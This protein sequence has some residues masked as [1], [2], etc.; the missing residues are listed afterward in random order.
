MMPLGEDLRADQQ[1]DR[2]VA[3]VAHQR[4]R[5]R[6]PADRVAGRH[7]H[8][9]ARQQA[10]NLFRQP[11]HAR[12][13]R[14]EAVFRA[15]LR[16]FAGQR[17]RV[18]AMMAFQPA[19]EP[20]FDQPGRALRAFQA[21]AAAA[22]QGERRI[23]PAVEIEQGLLPRRQ[24]FRD[25]VDHAAGEPA[26]ARRSFRA[27][28]EQFDRRHRGA[29][30]AF[31]QDQARIAPPFDIG[32]G[33]QR[34]RR[35]GEHR[36]NLLERRADDRH[37]PGVIDHAVFLLEALV[38]FLVDDDQAELGHRQH[39]GGA[40]TDDDP[41][42]AGCCGP[43]DPPPLGAGQV[44]MPGRRRGAE[45]LLETGEPLGAQGDFG[46]QDDR[47]PAL[48]QRLG[49][50]LEIDFGLARSGDSFEHEGRIPRADRPGERLRGNPLI[51]G[52][53]DSGAVRVRRRPVRADG[54]RRRFDQ[55]GLR[56]TG[57]DGRRHVR[58]SPEPLGRNG[59]CAGKRL[60]NALPLRCDPHTW[61]GGGRGGGRR[62]CKPVAGFR[63]RRIE[64]LRHRD[65]H[66][67]H[68]SRRGDGVGGDPVNE[69][70]VRDRQR[71]R[72]VAGDHC[73]EPVV[74][75]GAVGRAPDHARHPARPERH[76]YE[77]AGRNR[78]IR[79]YPV[80]VAAADR[81]RQ[82]HLRPVRARHAF[83]SADRP[84]EGSAA[85]RAGIAGLSWANG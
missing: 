21:Q 65:R 63:S 78:H 24:R 62:G 56:H 8:P 26:S 1:V 5:S 11:L 42:P 80:V 76:P 61:R 81:H 72:I 85:W 58:R 9:G 25:C 19:G 69:P 15:A 34:R 73:L 29:A 23:A 22:A 36:G 38:V 54:D 43:P 18:A 48:A 49:D 59:A 57:Q 28:V 6:R 4:F 60:Q 3:D 51:R 31:R 40:R 47:L 46:Q 55:A 27:Q 79:R 71:R 32:D 7:Q 84:A 66:A 45:A 82:Q 33:L 68:R 67:Q 52:Q 20:V 53:G 35:G 2:T 12:P 13:A 10:G 37:V 83:L 30:V 44:G 14:H 16:A 74:R 41:G 39:E 75:H 64:R 17:P 70:A 50:G 77:I